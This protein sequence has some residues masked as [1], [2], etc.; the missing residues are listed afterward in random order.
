MAGACGD[1]AHDAAVTAN[2]EP[3]PSP[4]GPGSGEPFLAPGPDG[5]A[6]LSWLEA[7]GGDTTAFR[8][9]EWTGEAWS[10][11]HTIAAGPDFFVNWADFPSILRLP[12]GRLAAHWLQREGEDTYAYGVRIAFSDDAG[13]TWSLPVTPHT[14]GT[15]T[16]HGFV[17]LFPDGEA[18]GAVWLD[19]RAMSGGHEANG[20]M[21]IRAAR[22]SPDGTLSLE[23][24]I[25]D[26]TC[27][28]CQTDVALTAAGPVVVYR[29]RSPEEVRNIVIARREGDRWTEPRPVYDDGW[30]LEGCPVNGPAV[31]AHDT[32][33]AVAWFAAPAG[34]PQVKVVFSDDAGATF[35][36]PIRVDGGA[37]AGRVDLLALNEGGVLVSWIER[38]QDGA[39]VRAR[40]VHPDGS[41]AAPIAVSG[42][43]AERAS[44][45]P[46]MT[47]VD[48]GVLF[49][50]TEPGDRAVVRVARIGL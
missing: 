4:A 25:D 1:A 42:T 22:I 46:R 19:G 32:R 33:V 27:E 24:R 31:V 11:P 41:L 39:E 16:E 28:C 6:L 3:L 44:G 34:E 47:Q 17:T 37:P 20:A 7:T 13:A 2:V 36:N 23:T 35:G 5:V 49:A 14:D 38:T 12:D 21:T 15:L 30:V 18:L 48:G 8:F 50:W 45:F 26:R 40:R 29:D 43:S 10:E 9:A